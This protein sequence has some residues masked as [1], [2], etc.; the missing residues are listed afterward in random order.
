MRSRFIVLG[1]AALG[2]A[3]ACSGSSSGN[4]GVALEDVPEQIVQAQCEAFERCLGDFFGLFN[5]DVDCVE[6]GRASADDEL[7]RIRRAIDDG[8]V[9]YDGELMQE[10]IDGIRDASCDLLNNSRITACERAIEGTVAI[11]GD[12]SDLEEC[13]G[14][15]YCKFGSSCPGTCTAYETEGGPCSQDDDVCAEG[16][17]CDDETER[18]VRPAGPG[19]RCGGGVEA[20]CGGGQFCAGEDEDNGM[21]GNCR[22]ASEVFTAKLGEDCDFFTG[23]L[24]EKDLSCSIVGFDETTGDLQWMC[25]AT[26]AS[27]G[28][29]N[30]SVPGTC[31]SGEYCD[32]PADDFQGTCRSV[33]A[34]GEPCATDLSGE[35][36]LCGPQ[37]GCDGGTC[38]A[39]QQIGGTCQSDEVCFSELCVGGVCVSDSRC[40]G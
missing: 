16:L 19:D 20:P 21:A 40:T 26:V 13:E 3:A 34:D 39:L 15:A 11:G 31:P 24:C 37:S 6:R 5:G 4:K 33:P 18:C 12:C 17:V 27:G 10:C 29:C 2:L 28:A 8:R 32:I 22:V 25:E 1:A 36:T 38:R 35:A 14:A 30:A 7:T 9:S 23:R